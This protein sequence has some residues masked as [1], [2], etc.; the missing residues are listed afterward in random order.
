MCVLLNSNGVN[1]TIVLARAICSTHVVG[2]ALRACRARDV[3]DTLANTIE[4]NAVFATLTSSIASNT[5][6]TL[7][8]N[9]RTRLC[10]GEG[11]Y[12]KQ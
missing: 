3:G 10:S 9:G 4:A 8:N 12:A 7:K 2:V 5:R 6:A 1:Y 11:N